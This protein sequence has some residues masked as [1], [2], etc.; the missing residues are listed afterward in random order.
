MAEIRSGE[1]SKMGL[2]CM[3]QC[4]DGEV[5]EVTALKAVG[6]SW[7]SVD[8]LQRACLELPVVVHFYHTG[9]R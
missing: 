6:G 2:R 7:P 8:A 3:T 9:T 5:I 1:T 4:C